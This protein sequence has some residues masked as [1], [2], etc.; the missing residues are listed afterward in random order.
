MVVIM[1]YLRIYPI[2]EEEPKSQYYRVWINGQESGTYTSYRF[3]TVRT[4]RRIKGRP[5]SDVSFTAFDFEGEVKIEI[6]LS[7]EPEQE[8]KVRPL[9]LNIKPKVDGKRIT[10]TL[11]K[12]A[13]FSVEPY[14]VFCP[15]HIFANPKETAVPD[16][17]GR[18]VHYF[19]PG[20]HEID[21]ISLCDGD[22]AYL[23]G[24]AFVYAKPQPQEK[25]SPFGL[26]NAFEMTWIDYT[27]K[28]QGVSGVR[29]CGRGVLCGR[30]TLEKGQRHRLLGILNSRDVTVEGVIFREGTS[31][32]VQTELSERVHIDNIK[33][34]GHFCNNDGV[35]I[36][37]SSDVLVENSYAHN[38]DDSFLVKAFRPVRN[39][40]F[41]NCVAWNDVSTSF[42]AVCEI[43]AEAENVTF[44]DCVVTH[45]TFPLWDHDSGGI[46]GIWNAYGGTARN[47][48]FERIIIEEACAGKE[49]IKIS[50]TWRD[51][52]LIDCVCLRDIQVLN[53]D[54]ERIAIYGDVSQSVNHITMEN[55]SIN[56]SAVDSKDDGRIINR[57][58]AEITII[59]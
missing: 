13:N 46:I 47:F 21:P 4:Q 27:L 28:C 55:I 59:K 11:N 9:N 23:E 37:D 15:L 30:R 58:D 1:D 6:L 39:V 40:D 44:R 26:V 56:G 49:P 54:D 16:L 50:V 42:G 29:I 35:D 12:P 24:G 19:P 48:L 5:V 2:A 8:T 14:G 31:W 32:S 36:C 51:E 25:T 34:L 45:S 53:T 22:T 41:R 33:V 17:D 43:A 10:F 7:C 38:A 57:C 18:G 3:D 20:V 52:G